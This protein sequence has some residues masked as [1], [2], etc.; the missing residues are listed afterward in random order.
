MALLGVSGAKPLTRASE[1]APPFDW[2]GVVLFVLRWLLGGA[3]VW[4]VNPVGV[5]DCLGLASQS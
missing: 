4:G 5:C 1:C 2:Q 3:L